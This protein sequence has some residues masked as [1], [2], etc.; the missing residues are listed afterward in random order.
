MI[1]D[2]DPL[3]VDT[4]SYVL[5]SDFEVSASSSRE[6]CI[7]QLRYVSLHFELCFI[8]F[9]FS[10]TLAHLYLKLPFIFVTTSLFF[11]LKVR[12][13]FFV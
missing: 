1:V 5:S 6:A 13:I 7:E 12:K 11:R 2:D 3:I 10:L 9:S 8:N 4:L